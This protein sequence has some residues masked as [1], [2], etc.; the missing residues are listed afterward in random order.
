MDELRVSFQKVPTKKSG[1]H[2]FVSYVNPGSGKR[3]RVKKKVSGLLPTE[4]AAQAWA[5]NHLPTLLK[6]EVALLNNQQWRSKSEVALLAHQFEAFK[7]LEFPKS[8]WQTTGALQNYVLPYF[9]TIA[10]LPD[11]N[12]W[13]PHHQRFKVW[14]LS[15]A[16]L[17]GTSKKLSVSTANKAINSLNKFC[18]WLRDHHQSLTYDSCRPL[19]AYPNKMLNRRGARD[20][21]TEEDMVLAVNSLRAKGNDL[22][23]DGIL[24]QRH[25]GMRLSELLGLSLSSLTTQV[26]D[27]LKE[28]F[29]SLGIDT[30]YGAIY[31]DSQPKHGYITRGID[32]SISRVPLKWRPE[33]S[34]KY[35][36]TIPIHDK[37]VWNILATRFQAQKDLLAKTLH[38]PNKENYL[39]F[40]KGQR[41]PYMAAVKEAYVSL[42]LIPKVSHLLRHTRITELTMLG[43]D[44]K[45]LELLMGNKALAQK[46]YQ[47]I[48]E[49]L[50]RKTIQDRDLQDIA[51]VA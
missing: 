19:K 18:E 36:R 23:A 13:Y 31:L 29:K 43:M 8:Y 47:H 17:P 7:K 15:D 51:I 46:L 20:L 14:L 37:A 48:V 25:T 3:K 22:E 16:N 9:V 6:K 41:T 49:V 39:L 12:S 4:E 50:N 27:K 24:V 42:G 40:D 34:P 11:P 45:M 26:P 33:I 1:D 21:V 2:W 28:T 5:K 32:G 10:D 38:G 30:I 44:D 35:A